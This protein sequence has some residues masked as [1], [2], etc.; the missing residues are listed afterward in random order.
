MDT[1][2]PDIVF[3]GSGVCNHCTD[4]IKLLHPAITKTERARRLEELVKEMK[5]KGRK[6]QYDCIIGVSGGVDSTYVAWLV[7]E[8]GLRPLAVHLDNGWDSELAV[9]N[10][11]KVIRR[12]GIDLYTYVLDWEEF[13]NLQLSFIKA[14]VPHCEHPTDH[15]IVSILYKIAD[16]YKVKYILSGSNLSTESVS[17]K[18]WSGGQMDWKYIKNVHKRYGTAKLKNYPHVSGAGLFYYRK[19]KRI[20]TVAILEYIDYNKQEAIEF[21]Q[22]ELG[23]IYY[24]GKHYESLYTK[25]F[26]TCILPEKFHIDKRK[27]HLSA[28]ICSGEMTRE[29]ALAALRKEIISPA[30]RNEDK[31]YVCK[32]LGIAEKEFD[33]YMNE[34]IKAFSDYP[35]YENSWYFKMLYPYFRRSAG[36]SRKYNA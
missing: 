18:S 33:A 22:K 36:I 5:D 14:S 26:Q 21:L 6:N 25:F 27:T 16:K 23:W 19:V 15:A 20:R 30:Q 34:P 2:D 4:A 11:E 3:D 17:V 10:V 28:L 12:L 13:R 8:L 35:S 1:T 29:E 24:G 9:S 32:K 31:E 7:K